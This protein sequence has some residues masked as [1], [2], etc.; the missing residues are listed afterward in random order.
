[1]D[2][3][4]EEFFDLERLLRETRKKKKIY[5]QKFEISKLFPWRKKKKGTRVMDFA[6]EESSPRSRETFE[7][8]EKK[9]KSILKNSKFRNSSHREKK[10][11][12]AVTNF[13]SP[14]S[15]ASPFESDACHGF[16][17]VDGRTKGRTRLIDRGTRLLFGRAQWSAYSWTRQDG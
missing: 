10:K 1:M 16:L 11:K 15:P 6:K 8:L 12:R 4:K 17:S 9:K 7:K 2:F 5:F 13:L 14:S 3:A